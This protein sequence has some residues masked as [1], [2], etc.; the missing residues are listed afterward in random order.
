LDHSVGYSQEWLEHPG[1]IVSSLDAGLVTPELNAESER[2]DGEVLDSLVAHA[3]APVSAPLSNPSITWYQE[4]LTI[5][6]GAVSL[7]FGLMDTMGA[8]SSWNCTDD[9]GSPDSTSSNWVWEYIHPWEESERDD[10]K[11]ERFVQTCGA[12]NALMGIAAIW[13]LRNIT[14]AAKASCFVT[15]PNTQEVAQFPEKV[16]RKRVEEL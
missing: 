4:I 1:L 13:Y 2:G 16:S 10:D 11:G 6:W 8:V 12:L 15:S 9:I 5:F 7:K 3:L 14:N